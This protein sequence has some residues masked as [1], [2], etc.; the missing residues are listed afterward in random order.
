MQVRARRPLPVSAARAA[1]LFRRVASSRNWR[2]P[3]ATTRWAA[4][5]DR[6]GGLA[7]GTSTG[8]LGGALAGRVGD[9]PP[10]GCGFYADDE[11]GAVVLSGDGEMIARVIAASRILHDLRSRPPGEAIRGTLDRVAALAGEAGAVLVMPDGRIVHGHNSREFCVASQRD[12]EPESTVT[13]R[14]TMER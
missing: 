12:G 11:M 4:W 1:G 5:R 2:A 13:L 3:T 8:G 9:S 14:G 10:P 7:A 6:S